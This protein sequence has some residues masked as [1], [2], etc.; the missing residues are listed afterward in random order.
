MPSIT[1]TDGYTFSNWGPLTTT[2]TAPAS[3]ATA[4]GNYM[5]GA[6]FEVPCFLFQAQCST[7]GF[8]GCVLT[9][10]ASVQQTL[11][12]NP[13]AMY[14]PEYF[15]P[16]LYCPSGWATEGIAARD[17]NNSLSSV[18]RGCN[19]TVPEYKFK[20][21]CVNLMPNEY[22]GKATK[23]L[24]EHQTTTE[25]LVATLTGTYP[26]TPSTTTVGTMAISELVGASVMPMLALIHHQS[27]LSET[28]SG[29]VKSSQTTST[30]NA[31]AKGAPSPRTWNNL[32]ALFGI[33][34]AAMVLGAA[35]VLP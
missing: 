23:T 5:I 17:A 30:S 7:D 29:T 6:K 2:F 8:F 27:D 19:S 24:V 1:I 4:T 34:V 12:R 26:V 33:S 14:H 18:A 20:E 28:G 15:S 3:C 13:S 16:G 22:V 35:V 11:D 31:A 32:G 10:T 9:G 21:A 25:E